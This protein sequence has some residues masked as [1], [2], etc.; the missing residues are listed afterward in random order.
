MKFKN[1]KAF[2]LSE[3]LIAIAIIGF[4]ASLTILGINRGTD[5]QSVVAKLNKAYKNLDAAFASA[6]LE[7][8]TP[9]KMAS[10]GATAVVANIFPKLNIIH[11]CGT[12]SGCFATSMT[13]FTET[14]TMAKAVLT[15]D[16]AIAILLRAGA[17]NTVLGQNDYGTVTVDVDGKK[18][19]NA[20]SR[21]IFQFFITEDGL[22]PAGTNITDISTYTATPANATAWAIYKGN[23][24]YLRCPAS[25][26]WTDTTKWH[27]T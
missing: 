26:S 6:T 10:S 15:D 2:T 27:C 3:T 12:T 25:L 22:F 4:V 21:D 1:N 20:M 5:E 13:G 8:A 19:S 17:N 14:A 24:D 11:S 16:I 18:G 7:G 9:S 23:L